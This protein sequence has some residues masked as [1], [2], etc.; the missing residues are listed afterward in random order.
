MAACK[1][2]RTI[3]IIIFAVFTLAAQD[4]IAQPAPAPAP[5]PAPAPAETQGV[6]EGTEG[7]A[8]YGN[9]TCEQGLACDSTRN[10]CFTPTVGEIGGA[11]YGNRTCNAGY[12]C[13]VSSNQCV[14][15]QAAPP[16]TPPA[17]A[18]APPSYPP[19]P[20]APLPPAQPQDAYAHHDG[21]SVGGGLGVSVLTGFGGDSASALAVDFNLG[22]FLSPR[23][24]LHYDYSTWFDSEDI[25]GARVSL[26]VSLHAIAAQYWLAPKLW[27]KGG[28]GV[29]VITFGISGEDVDGNDVD[30][31]LLEESGAGFTGAVGFD[32]FTRGAFAVDLSGRISNMSILEGNFT[33]FNFVAG[34]RWH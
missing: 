2:L 19:P 18:A 4:A 25:G 31:T 14:A 21:L 8:C 20:P 5:V 13:D 33:T 23:L 22:W 34:A 29:A 24:A 10:V 9:A 32:V 1:V 16:S 7:G 27:L 3:A 28:A 26:G 15:A 30:G 6:A 11:C 12:T 17:P